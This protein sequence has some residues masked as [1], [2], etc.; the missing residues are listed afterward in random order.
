MGETV[1]L[2]IIL[3]AALAMTALKLKGQFRRG[4]CGNC[5]CGGGGKYMSLNAGHRKND[6]PSRHL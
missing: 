3:I 2:L 1:I 6:T 5:G 4:G